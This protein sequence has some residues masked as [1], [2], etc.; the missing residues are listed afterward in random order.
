MTA[1]TLVLFFTSCA[2][3]SNPKQAAG[4]D[5]K[6]TMFGQRMGFST[7]GQALYFN[8]FL[9]PSMTA[10]TQVLFPFDMTKSSTFRIL[11]TYF[12]YDCVISGS[13]S[14]CSSYYRFQILEA[15]SQ[16]VVFDDVQTNNSY[17]LNSG[18]SYFLGFSFS[19]LAN[20]GSNFTLNF[21]V[22]KGDAVS[23]VASASCSSE[24]DI[25]QLSRSAV[26]VNPQTNK[27][28]LFDSQTACGVPITSDFKYFADFSLSKTGAAG[29]THYY[30]SNKKDLWD[31]KSINYELQINK[32][33]QT[34]KLNL[35]CMTYP[36]NRQ[37]LKVLV[38]RT[39]EVCSSTVI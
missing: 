2:K 12:Y 31:T 22:W 17:S 10:K 32:D 8:E 24:G 9:A 23:T 21:S 6:V 13:P 28:V 30:L 3:K 11:S 27:Q 34:G 5:E 25:V 14:R 35:L 37:T 29:G 7:E 18:R 4:G 15:D 16:K 33:A 26:V 1:I 36:E 19:D 38:E 39:L 20:S